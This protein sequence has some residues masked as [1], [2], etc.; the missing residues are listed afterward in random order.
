MRAA[1]VQA[2]TAPPGPQRAGA[3]PGAPPSGPPFKA[4]LVDNVARTA[5]AEGQNPET[6]ADAGP[7]GHSASSTRA[8]RVADPASTERTS[9][10]PLTAG[11]GGQ[12]A[13]TP[14]VRT[15]ATAAPAVSKTPT[16]DSTPTGAAGTALAAAIETT[17]QVAASSLPA[18]GRRDGPRGTDDRLD[19]A[20]AAG[21]AATAGSRGARNATTSARASAAAER[22]AAAT[23]Q[24]AAAAALPATTR[25]GGPQP[26]V[27]TPGS[28][29]RGG[30]SSDR[31]TAGAVSTGAGT[32]GA[33]TTGARG[34]AGAATAA[35]SVGVRIAGAHAAPITD[36]HRTASL[37]TGF[38]SAGGQVTAP[39][40]TAVA[41]SGPARGPAAPTTIGRYGVTLEHAAQTVRLTV[42]TA[43]STGASLARI[44]LSPAELGGIHVQLQ[45]TAAGLIARVV[46]DHPA[47]A[48]VLEQAGGELRRALEGSGISLLG[49]DIG[50]SG[51]QSG[52]PEPQMAPL[53]D[54][55][56][57]EPEPTVNDQSADASAPLDSPITLELANGALVDILA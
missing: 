54:A 29:E 47:A 2:R 32:T 4:L 48:H 42:A 27:S 25:A 17:V 45:Q 41:S 56:P 14:H 30:R 10:A 13:A 19:G 28:R 44:R 57:P 23:S 16:P 53:P 43:A 51:Q 24:A 3:P 15:D 33:G 6:A 40:A 50:A 26:P 1:A 11:A 39:A 35:A 7:H 55:R 21:G 46:A 31:T 5:P 22:S 49:L 8:T 9:A 52:R 34:V 12:P 20:V 38:T 37:P 18:G 36:G